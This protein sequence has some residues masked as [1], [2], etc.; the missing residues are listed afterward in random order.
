MRMRESKE[1][2]L[3]M[4]RDAMSFLVPEELLASYL[5]AQSPEE[6]RRLHI[7]IF[8]D[9]DPLGRCIAPL[10]SMRHNID[11][12][13]GYVRLLHPVLIGQLEERVVNFHGRERS[14]RTLSIA[15]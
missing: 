11:V 7:A 12:T 3:A 14:R 13:P 4:P 5:C 15:A 6:R 8:Y 2:P 1:E 10:G 9:K